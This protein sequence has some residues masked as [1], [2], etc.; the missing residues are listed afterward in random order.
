MKKIFPALIVVL[1]IAAAILT[2]CTSA[3]WNRTT[4]Y[5]TPKLVVNNGGP[6]VVQIYIS[7]GRVEDV[8]NSDG[9]YFTELRGGNLIQVGGDVFIA[10][11]T[12]EQIGAY[13]NAFTRAE[14]VQALLQ[15]IQDDGT[16][17]RQS[18]ACQ[19]AE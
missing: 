4:D 12:E 19:P 5:A 8:S 10:D 17:V 11:A 6:C 2:A 3:G 16:I 9:W 13:E 14:A 1:L 15:L 7:K 18:A